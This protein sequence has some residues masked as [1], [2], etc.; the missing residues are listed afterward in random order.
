[1]RVVILGCGRVGAKVAEVLDGDGHD[2][3]IIDRKSDAFGRLSPSYRGRAVVGLG[4]DEDTLVRADLGSAD[5]F[6]ALSDGDNTNVMAAQ[7]A[8]H[9][10]NVPYV[11]SQIKDPI[12]GEA[13]E[14]LGIMTICPTCIGAD[15]IREVISAKE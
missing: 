4:I 14:G 5:V 10:F 2:V 11:I 13:Y 12:R 1:M 9:V 15:A 3:L 6:I 7:V 8:K